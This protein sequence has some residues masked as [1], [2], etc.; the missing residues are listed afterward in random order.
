MFYEFMKIQFVLIN[1]WSKTIYSTHTVFW[2]KNKILLSLPCSSKFIFF[3]VN[4]YGRLPMLSESCTSLSSCRVNVF[5]VYQLAFFKWNRSFHWFLC[6]TIRTN[7]RLRKDEFYY[8]KMIHKRI[9]EICEI[10]R[11]V[12]W[13]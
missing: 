11:I 4:H 12:D 1:A 13:F 6:Y 7:R 3:Q 9:I 2:I 10:Y 5:V 8:F